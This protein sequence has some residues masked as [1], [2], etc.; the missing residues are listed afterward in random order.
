MVHPGTTH[1]WDTEGQPCVCAQV[2]ARTCAFIYL[3]T[4]SNLC[5]DCETNPLQRVLRP[6]PWSQKMSWL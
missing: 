5:H 3:Q 6:H 4:Y 1:P 2:C